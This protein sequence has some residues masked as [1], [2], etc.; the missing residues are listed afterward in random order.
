MDN[1]TKKYG[2]IFQIKLGSFDT[3]VIADYHLM[4]KKAFHTNEL[5]GRPKIHVFELASQGFHG[6]LSYY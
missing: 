6:K 5:S 1:F 4:I 3:V 2:P